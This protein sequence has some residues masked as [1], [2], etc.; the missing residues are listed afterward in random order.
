MQTATVVWVEKEQI[1]AT[2][3]S[4]HKIPID[5]DRTHNAAPGPME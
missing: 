5:A 1:V 4:G 3:P 2:L